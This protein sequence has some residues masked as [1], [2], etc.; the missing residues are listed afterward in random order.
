MIARCPNTC[1][2]GSKQNAVKDKP[3]CRNIS[4]SDS[5]K[6]K[7]EFAVDLIMKNTSEKKD[8]KYIVDWYGYG[9]SHVTVA[10]IDHI[11]QQIDTRYLRQY[12]ENIIYLSILRIQSNTNYTKKQKTITIFYSSPKVSWFIFLYRYRP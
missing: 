2:S 7:E 12:R 5:H 11:P 1:K 3:S 6:T 10:S 9:P 4:W 8:V